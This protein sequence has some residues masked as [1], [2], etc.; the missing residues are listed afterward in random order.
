MVKL[1]VHLHEG[2]LHMLDMRGRVFHQPLPVTQIGTECGDL[3]I[4]AKASA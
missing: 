2:L 3:G 4:R 1:E